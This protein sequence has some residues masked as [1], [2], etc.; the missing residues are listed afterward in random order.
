MPCGFL[1][2]QPFRVE[3]WVSGWVEQAADSLLAAGEATITTSRGTLRARL[4]RPGRWRA[5][6]LSIDSHG[7]NGVTG[8]TSSTVGRGDEHDLREEIRWRLICDITGL[9]GG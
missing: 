4:A 9:V 8:R 3:D 1:A 5:G 2:G 6:L 7:D